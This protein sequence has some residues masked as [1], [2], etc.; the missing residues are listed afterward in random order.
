MTA[1][2]EGGLTNY[3]RSRLQYLRTEG[4]GA[5]AQD[6]SATPHCAKALFDAGHATRWHD[7]RRWRYTISD[8]GIAYLE[9]AQVK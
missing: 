1:A 6:F 8:A 9:K 7:G 4:S 2:P 5:A 3:Q